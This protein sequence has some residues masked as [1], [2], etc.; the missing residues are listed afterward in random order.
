MDFKYLLVQKT[1]CF[2][3]PFGAGN[4]GFNILSNSEKVNIVNAKSSSSIT[5][6]G[7]MN[8]QEEV[9]AYAFKYNFFDKFGVT[10]IHLAKV[11]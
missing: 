1:L 11:C 4:L 5:L 3:A 2:S 8:V 6:S 9:T 10:S 7:W